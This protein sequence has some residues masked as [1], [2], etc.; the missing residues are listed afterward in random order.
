MREFGTDI[1]IFDNGVFVTGS[2]DGLPYLVKF[3]NEGNMEIN[4]SIIR[5]GP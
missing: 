1:L 2:E 3:D 5:M 4:K